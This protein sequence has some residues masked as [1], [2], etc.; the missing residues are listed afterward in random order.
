MSE[1]K[2][3]ISY[4][5]K[6]SLAISHRAKLLWY[7]TR[8][9]DYPR[10]K[11]P[12][13]ID[14]LYVQ[15]LADNYISRIIEN[16]RVIPEFESN[17]VEEIVDQWGMDDFLTDEHYCSQNDRERVLNGWKNGIESVTG[18]DLDCL[19]S[20]VLLSSNTEWVIELVRASLEHES[21]FHNRRDG[22]PY[23]CDEWGVWEP[24]VLENLG[25][26]GSVLR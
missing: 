9:K 11:G 25:S 4:S 23:L 13:F 12:Q 24:S 3:K 16:P 22:Y 17:L 2:D 6:L 26:W 19:V 14:F 18:Y 20:G 1:E 7:G 15:V 10:S 8:L 21:G 5:S